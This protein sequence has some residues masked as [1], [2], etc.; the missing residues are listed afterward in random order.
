MKD[1]KADEN[2]FVYIGSLGEPRNDTWVEDTIFIVMD[3]FDKVCTFLTVLFIISTIF[4][5]IGWYIQEKHV[6]K[7]YFMKKTSVIISKKVSKAS[8]ELLVKANIILNEIITTGISKG[9][10][11]HVRNYALPAKQ[12]ILPSGKNFKTPSPRQNNSPV[13]PLGQDSPDTDKAISMVKI[14]PNFYFF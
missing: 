2:R 4:L 9:N 5:I 6:P 10:F 1:Y 3:T 14:C 11:R 7:A 13:V 12:V 8:N